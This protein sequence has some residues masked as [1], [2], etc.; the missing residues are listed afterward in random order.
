[1]DSY[2]KLYYLKLTLREYT[3]DMQDEVDNCF[4]QLIVLPLQRAWRSRA[5]KRVPV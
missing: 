5:L 4:I 2:E 1:M 3:P